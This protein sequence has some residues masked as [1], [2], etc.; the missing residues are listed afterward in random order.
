MHSMK[1]ILAAG[2]ALALVACGG[3]N[4]DR[5]VTLSVA[6]PSSNASALSAAVTTT[7]GADGLTL[8]DG[9]NTLIIT[10]AEVV[11]REIELERTDSR[12]DF[13]TGPRIVDLPLDG[14]VSEQA[15]TAVPEGTYNELEFEIHKLSDDNGSELL[16]ERPD[17]RDVSV[18]VVGTFNGAAFDFVTDESFEQEI[19][20]DPPI[21]VAA[22]G[23]DLNVTLSIDLG[24]W[25][26]NASGLLLDPSTNRSQIEDNLDD[27]YSC[28][29]DDDRDGRHDDDDHDDDHGGDRDRNRGGDDDRSGRDHPE[30]D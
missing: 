8:A 19:R 23:A 12:H 17:L 2:V 30:D 21:V 14:S 1:N 10:R 7:P 27:G 5:Q 9:T 18:H 25:F 26:T 13:E 20:L 11:L 29:D 22:G 4:D 24:K 16:R 3:G 28:F 6:V 15:V